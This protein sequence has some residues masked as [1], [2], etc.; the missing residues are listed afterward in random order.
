MVDFLNK[1]LLIISMIV[2]SS[3]FC[4]EDQSLKPNA[5]GAAGNKYSHRNDRAVLE[6]A[7]EKLMSEDLNNIKKIKH[8]WQLAP[9]IGRDVEIFGRAIVPWGEKGAQG[10]GI[11]GD[12]NL[13]IG[14]VYKE[15]LTDQGVLLKKQGSYEISDYVILRGK[16]SFNF[17]GARYEEDAKIINCDSDPYFSLDWIEIKV[18]SG[19]THHAKDQPSS[20]RLSTPTKQAIERFN[21]LF[22]GLADQCDMNAY[23]SYIQELRGN[24]LKNGNIKNHQGNKSKSWHNQ[25]IDKLSEIGDISD[26][27][28]F[29]GSYVEIKGDLVKNSDG[30]YCLLL[31]KR[32][33]I[34][35][36]TFVGYENF[37]YIGKHVLCRCFL[38]FVNE[39]GGKKVK[40]HF[41]IHG[42]EYQL[43]VDKKKAD[44]LDQPTL[45]KIPFTAEWEK[46]RRGF[47]TG[48]CFD[49]NY[50]N[51]RSYIIDLMAK[52]KLQAKSE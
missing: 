39:E 34:K 35:L 14:G 41:A 26:L 32:K 12:D 48:F 11:N 38:I 52:E 24:Y 49:A 10:F 30:E 27:I 4:A 22:L 25:S 28:P 15:W 23:A 37:N 17:L 51:L 2:S 3:V 36:N 45:R 40:P 43:C 8:L 18:S 1:V 42:A 31:N 20:I 46:V 6:T 7:F 29:I 50:I 13:I 19:K 21:F 5:A 33:N 44:T 47:I 9:F 16:L